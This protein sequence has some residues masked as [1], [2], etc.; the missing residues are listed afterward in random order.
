MAT[1]RAIM[2]AGAVLAV[3][4]AVA[5]AQAQRG[6]AGAPLQ[7]VPGADQATRHGATKPATKSTT[8]KAAKRATPA[9]TVRAA[10]KTD[11]EHARAKPRAADRSNARSTAQPTGRNAARTAAASQKRARKARGQSA[12][13][14]ITA[15]MPE[16]KGKQRP[17][18][19]LAFTPM[20][21]QQ[22]A[23]PESGNPASRGATPRA[24]DNHDTQDET[25]DRV[26]RDGDSVS[27]IARLPWWRNDRL[28]PVRY[29]S[30][31]AESQVMAAA[32]AWQLASATVDVP[33]TD[34]GRGRD[35][36]SRQGSESRGGESRGGDHVV[37]AEAG[38]LNA[39][40]RA[41][42]AVSP[43]YVPTFWHSLIAVLGGALAAVLAALASARF[44][45]A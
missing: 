25:G 30:P 21:S 14:A 5:P 20:P 10:R 40:D 44:I 11:N 41:F 23:A 16:L 39:I 29:G 42:A 26:M 7:L 12:Q 15:A 19:S 13:Q 34:E 6:Q 28:Q 27:L 4:Q 36:S 33:A 22:A 24:S 17:E 43:P 38:E 1:V 8:R 18:P 45:F 9:R 37:V 31:A 3:L 32:R 2:I 35:A